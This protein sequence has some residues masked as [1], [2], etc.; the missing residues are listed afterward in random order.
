M[1]EK[2][3]HDYLAYL[4]EYDLAGFPCIKRFAWLLLRTTFPIVLFFR[5]SGHRSILV[6]CIAIP[7][8]KL[9]R[10]ISG[11]QIPRQTKIGKG[12]L[13]PHYGCVVLNKKSVYGEYLTIHQCV[14]VGFKG[15]ASKDTKSPRIGNHVRLSAGAIVLGDIEIGDNVTVGAG[16]VVVKSVSSNSVVVGSPAYPLKK[17]DNQSS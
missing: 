9:I 15:Y 14:T 13:I 7:V 12:L 16:A 10:I 11:V 6:R 17:T 5:L 3:Y 1:S 2:L 4:E 8:Y